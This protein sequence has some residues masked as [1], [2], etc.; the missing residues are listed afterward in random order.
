VKTPHWLMLAVAAGVIAY[1]TYQMLGQDP[2]GGFN[3]PPRQPQADN[4][5]ARITTY[6]DHLCHP[7]EHY[8]GYTYT[9]HRFPRQCGGEITNAIHHGWSSMRV[10]ASQDVQWLIAPPSEV[11]F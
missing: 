3:Q 11:M 6:Q 10:P 1:V 2:T 8:N 5:V 7:A 9:P 4:D